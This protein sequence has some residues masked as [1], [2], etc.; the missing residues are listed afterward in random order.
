MSDGIDDGDISSAVDG[1][2][3]R[4]QSITI[5]VIE[6]RRRVDICQLFE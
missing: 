2:S 6:K 5:E 3:G 1:T 4:P